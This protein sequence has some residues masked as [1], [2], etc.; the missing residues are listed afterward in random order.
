MAGYFVFAPG[1]NNIGFS[2]GNKY[3]LGVHLDILTDTLYYTD[4]SKIYEWEGTNDSTD[5]IYTWKSGKIRIDHEVN[6]GAA[7]VQAD[8]YSDV[9]FKLWADISGTMVLKKTQTVASNEPFRLPG[10]YLSDTYEVQV[11]G[12]DVVTGIHVGESIF[13]LAK[14]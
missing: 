7:V 5:L 12:T 8:S 3:A 4:G 14:A 1:N 9:V 2:T 13:E 6:L 10:G 11:L